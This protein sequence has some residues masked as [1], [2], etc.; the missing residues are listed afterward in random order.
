MP[1]RNGPA[2]VGRGHMKDRRGFGRRRSSIGMHSMRHND[3]FVIPRI[4][5]DMWDNTFSNHGSGYTRDMN[6]TNRSSMVAAVDEHACRACGACVD[7]CPENAI[8]VDNDVARID[9]R[10]CRG[11][12]VCIESC[13]F[14]AIS[15]S[16]TLPEEKNL[17]EHY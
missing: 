16:Y 9:T 4:S 7:A 15:M 11:C 14:G 12:S 1:R 3:I 13:P 8:S 6:R 5:S 2:S 10:R 17:K